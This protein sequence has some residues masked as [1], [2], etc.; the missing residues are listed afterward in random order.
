MLLPDSPDKL[1]SHSVSVAVL[2]SQ[3]ET[4]TKVRD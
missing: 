2:L 4:E 1:L 3:I